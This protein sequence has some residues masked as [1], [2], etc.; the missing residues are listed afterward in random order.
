MGR[1]SAK[2]GDRET[3]AAVRPSRR[4]DKSSGIFSRNKIES[5]QVENGSNSLGQDSGRSAASQSIDNSSRRH[6]KLEAAPKRLRSELERRKSR[7][8]R[9]GAAIALGIVLMF[10]VLAAG[11]FVYYKSLEGQ[12]QKGIESNKKLNLT[13][14]KAEPKK[15][16]NMLIMGYDKRKGESSYR[17]DSMM[18]TRIDPVQKKVWIISLPRDY[19]VQIPGHGTQKLNAAYAFGQEEL[20]ISTVEK[21]TGQKI[22]HYMG[23]DFKGFKAIVDAI[24]GVEIDVPYKI[25]DPK[26]DYTAKK[27]ASKIDKGLQLLDGAHAL[28][29]VRTR[30]FPDADFSRMRNQQLFFMSLADTVSQNV[31]TSELPGVAKAVVPYL[32]TNMSLVQL[33]AMANDLRGAG[34][35]NIYTTSL[36]GD[37]KSPYIVPDEVAKAEI[38]RK[39]SE[40]IPFNITPEEEAATTNK[41]AKPADVQITVR[42]GTSRVGVAKQAAAVLKTRGFV[43]GE[44]G[45]TQNQSVY[46]ETLLVYKTSKPSATLVLKYLQPGVKIVESRGMYTYDTEVMLI[47]GKDWDIEKLPVA[48]IS[49]N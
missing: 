35:S 11:G 2:R 14:K 29:F 16:Y 48:D 7:N 38:M 43:V 23:V 8:K 45:N 27:T 34:S 3:R 39:F 4:K 15:P 42:N 5:S 36:P 47:I 30:D 21:L 28:T 37:W 20:T 19:K 12:L 6:G 32:S 26:A 41:G 18:L 44:V 46:E 22:N 9:L 24:G 13:L 17:S 25:N 10:V 31:S 1:H 40:G 49:E 33:Y